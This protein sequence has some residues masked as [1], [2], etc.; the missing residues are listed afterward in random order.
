M[1]DISVLETRRDVVGSR[2]KLAWT[3][4]LDEIADECFGRWRAVLQQA[5]TLLVFLQVRKVLQGILR[6]IRRYRIEEDAVTAADHGFG[7]WTIRQAEARAPIALIRRV[8]RAREF[9]AGSPP[10]GRELQVGGI[11]E[12][13]SASLKVGGSRERIREGGD[14]VRRLDRR[15]VVHIPQTDVDRQLRIDLPVI[16]QESGVLGGSQILEKAADPPSFLAR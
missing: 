2:R 8:H 6:D 13:G 15:R 1:L 16:L 14:P 5:Q 11:Q 10:I 4:I 3:G 7:K 9:L 12:E